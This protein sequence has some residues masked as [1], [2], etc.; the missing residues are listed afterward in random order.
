MKKLSEGRK[1]F[2]SVMV[3][4]VIYAIIFILFEDYDRNFL[5]PFE[6]TSDWH[7]LLYPEHLT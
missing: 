2:L 1:M 5:M 6:E 7:L 4:F 3:I